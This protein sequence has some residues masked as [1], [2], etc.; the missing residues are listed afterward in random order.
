MAIIQRT[1]ATGE[2]TQGHGPEKLVMVR[3]GELF[4]KSEAV[5][6]HFI[7]ILLRNIRKALSASGITCHYETPRGRIL[8]YGTEPE[9]IVAIVSRIFGIVDVS[10]CYRTSTSLGD[11]EAVALM[12]AAPRLSAG[13]SF[14][15]RAKRQYKTGLNSQ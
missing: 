14:A 15:V 1:M 10:I 12:L 2:E 13:M 4:L 11:L 7:G 9:R 5:K 8:I 3:Y 6:Y